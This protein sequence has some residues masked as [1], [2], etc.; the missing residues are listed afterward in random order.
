MSE[1]ALPDVYRYGWAEREVAYAGAL[2]LLTRDE[3][4]YTA[5]KHAWEKALRMRRAL[6][7]SERR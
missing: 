5:Y 3:E 6:T 7:P 1:S 4:D 2:W